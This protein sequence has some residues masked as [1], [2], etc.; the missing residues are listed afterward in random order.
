MPQSFDVGDV[1]GPTPGW[2]TLVRRGLA[3]RC[4]RCGDRHVFVHRYRLAERCPACGVRFTR[5]PGFFLGAWFVNF[6]VLEVLHWLLVMAFIVWRASDP[7]AGLLLPLVVGV[8]TAVAVPI[9][10]YPRSLT[11]WAAIDLAM[12]PLEL[13]EIVDAADAVAEDHDAGT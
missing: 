4:P 1:L 3:R 9:A 13:G 6:M 5:E 11:V 12:T 8:V 7:A 10:F 2:G